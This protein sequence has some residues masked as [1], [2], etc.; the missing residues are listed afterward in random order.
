MPVSIAKM[1]V[2]TIPVLMLTLYAK[3]H[4]RIFSTLFEDDTFAAKRGPLVLWEET[5]LQFIIRMYVTVHFSLWIVWVLFLH[6]VANRMTPLSS[7]A[8]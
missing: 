3:Y 7:V 2:Y 4:Y 1:L 8:W 6:H 5:M